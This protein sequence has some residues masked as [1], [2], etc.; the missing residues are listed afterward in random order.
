MHL[1]RRSSYRPTL[2]DADVFSTAEICLS[3]GPSASGTQ[4]FVDS[5]LK[6]YTGEMLSIEIV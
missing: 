6:R 5:L 2:R 3:C 1:S 4:R